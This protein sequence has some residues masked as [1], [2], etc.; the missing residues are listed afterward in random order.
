MLV[1]LVPA[2]LFNLV[3]SFKP[4]MQAFAP[5][6]S[7]LIS[8]S[9]TALIDQLV[10]I[11]QHVLET[12]V[13]GALEH[14]V[15]VKIDDIVLNL[16]MYVRQCIYNKKYI[17]LYRRSGNFHVMKLLYDKFSCKKFF[18]RNDPLPCYHYSCVL[19]F[20][21]AI[22]YENI[23]T[24]KT[25]RFYSNIKLPSLTLKRLGILCG[26]GT[27]STKSNVQSYNSACMLNVSGYIQILRFLGQSANI[28][29]H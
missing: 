21:A 29:K 14:L 3:K 23:F 22:D 24:T 28:P 5:D 25:S 8:E 6:G 20:V 7:V 16:M 18:C 17:N 26:N 11:V 13:E 10:S 27:G 9:N 12:K 1:K 19:I 4:F 2:L 15:H